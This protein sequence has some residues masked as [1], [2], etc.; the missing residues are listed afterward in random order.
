MFYRKEKHPTFV[1]SPV[2][3]VS[4]TKHI[5]DFDANQSVYV[6]LSNLLLRE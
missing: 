3:N 4:F 6:F 1:G 2:W 5:V